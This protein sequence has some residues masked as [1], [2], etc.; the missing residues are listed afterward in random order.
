LPVCDVEVIAPGWPRVSE[1]DPEHPIRVGQAGRRIGAK[2][3]LELVAENEVFKR[4]VATRSEGGKDS[5]DQER[6][7]E[8]PG[9][10]A[11]GRCS[12]ELDR[13]LPPFSQPLRWPADHGLRSDNYEVPL[14]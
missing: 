6:V 10:V 1:P 3:H 14:P 11:L 8:A 9:R 2:G 12:H 5:A 7:V 13:L 4:D